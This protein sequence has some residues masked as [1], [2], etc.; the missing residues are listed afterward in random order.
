MN[1]ASHYQRL[2]S[3]AQQRERLPGYVEI[4]HIVP[5]CLG[6][7]DCLENLV[8]LTPEEHFVAHQLLVKI[9]PENSKLVYAAVMMTSSSKFTVRRNKTYGWLRRLVSEHKRQ[10][11]IGV[12]HSEKSRRARSEKLKGKPLSDETKLKLKL[13]WERRRLEKPMTEETRRKLS[14][15]AKNKRHTAETKIKLSI[16]RKTNPVRREVPSHA[17]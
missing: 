10:S 1:Y 6:G 15:A 13:A 12:K 11:Q 5:R 4:H 2:I 16:F 7:S 9:Y 17:V 3:R 14:E 8:A